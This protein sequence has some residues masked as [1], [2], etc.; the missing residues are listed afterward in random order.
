MNFELKNGTIEELINSII[1]FIMEVY[2]A[3]QQ[4]F[5]KTSGMDDPNNWPNG[6]I[7]E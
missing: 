1:E 2:E 7:V 6:E 4:A 3:L 5:K